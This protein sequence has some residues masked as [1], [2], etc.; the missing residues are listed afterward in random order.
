MH[1]LDLCYADDS[2]SDYNVDCYCSNVGS[3]GCYI[4]YYSSVGGLDSGS[5]GCPDG[6]TVAG[7]EVEGD[8]ALDVVGN[9]PFDDPCVA[10][11]AIVDG[12]LEIPLVVVVAPCSN[13]RGLLSVRAV[14]C[15]G[16]SFVVRESPSALDVLLVP[17]KVRCVELM[18]H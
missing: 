12:P 9:G 18:G 6:G 8:R 14:A 13:V 3:H 7:N 1:N 11:F 4:V 15:V 5:G 16:L 10:D 17:P 2:F